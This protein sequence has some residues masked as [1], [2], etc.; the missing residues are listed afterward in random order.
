MILPRNIIVAAY[1]G[2]K[3]KLREHEWFQ[4]SLDEGRVP[5]TSAEQTRIVEEV[6]DETPGRGLLELDFLRVRAAR[7]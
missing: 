1:S 7:R 6:L 5:K 4:Q 3:D 2:L